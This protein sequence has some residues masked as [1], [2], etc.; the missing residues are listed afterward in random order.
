MIVLEHSLVVD[1]PPEAVFDY[2]AEPVHYVEW[3]PA[4]ERAEVVGGAELGPGARLRLLV[5]GPGR[6]IEAEAEVTTFERPRR[7]ALRTLSGP[8]RVVADCDLEPNSAGG[9]QVRLKV[10]IELGGVLRFG[11]GMVRDRITR[12]LPTLLEDLRARIEAETPPLPVQPS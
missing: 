5:R 7:L 8:A 9:T 1:R 6:P 4:I 3:Q 10:Q 11:E 2:L 12:E